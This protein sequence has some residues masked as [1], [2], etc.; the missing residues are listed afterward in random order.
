MHRTHPPRPLPP[1]ARLCL[2]LVL[3]ACA[4]GCRN[5]ADLSPLRQGAEK[6]RIGTDN[7]PRQYRELGFV[8]AIH[9]HGCGRR[10]ERGTYAG[11]LRLVRNLALDRRADYVQ[12]L[13]IIEPHALA[14][15]CFD[16]RFSIRVVLYRRLG[17]R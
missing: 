17:R 7:P 10:G 8:T 9:G 13:S 16:N 15:G 11:A 1:V 3:A 12:I 2:L 5:T 14:D 6:I 4:A